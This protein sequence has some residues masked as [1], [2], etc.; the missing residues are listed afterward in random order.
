MFKAFQGHLTKS[1]WVTKGEYLQE[2]RGFPI[3]SG[4]FPATFPLNQPIATETSWIL[5][6]SSF[7]D[8]Q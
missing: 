1:P 3:F 6:Y 2:T 7:C 8:I 5:T 4:G